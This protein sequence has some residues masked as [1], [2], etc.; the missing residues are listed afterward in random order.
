MIMNVK[1]LQI[2]RDFEYEAKN[3]TE[4]C[5]RKILWMKASDFIVRHSVSI[6]SA[7]NGSGNITAAFG[8]GDSA[9]IERMSIGKLF[10]NILLVS[11]VVNSCSV[12]F[13]QYFRR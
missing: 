3:D 11:Y 8:I 1:L 9:D 2:I 4:E 12:V 6:R 13:L 10:P 5:D 7:R